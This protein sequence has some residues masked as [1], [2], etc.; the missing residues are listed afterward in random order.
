MRFHIFNDCAWNL[1]RAQLFSKRRF[2]STFG[3]NKQVQCDNGN[4]NVSFMIR[5]GASFVFDIRRNK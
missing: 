5:F 3:K 4:C 2:M 1:R